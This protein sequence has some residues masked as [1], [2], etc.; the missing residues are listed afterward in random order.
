[1]NNLSHWK[2]YCQLRDIE[3]RILLHIY[4]FRCLTLDQI[5][6]LLYPKEQDRTEQSKQYVLHRCYILVRLKIL[7]KETKRNEYKIFFLTSKGIDCLR[8]HG[9]L[10]AEI[11]LNDKNI[12]GYLTAKELQVSSPAL[13]HQIALNNF[14]IQ[15][16]QKS[17]INSLNSTFRLLF[18]HIFKPDGIIS[19]KDLDIFLEMDM[20]TESRTV[21]N[22]K[23][24]RYSH[25]LNNY[26]DKLNNT[27]LF[28][29]DCSL[30]GRS[31]LEGRISLVRDS[32][33][34]EMGSLMNGHIEAYIGDA[35]ELIGTLKNVVENRALLWQWAYAN[36]YFPYNTNAYEELFNGIRF[37]CLF[38]DSKTYM[39]CDYYESCR[40][41]V[42]YKLYRIEQ[43]SRLFFNSQKSKFQYF[44][45]LKE[46]EL[47]PFIE[48]VKDLKLYSVVQS[49]LVKIVKLEI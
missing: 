25:Y 26:K 21:L 1:M 38:I 31:S 12:C 43:L 2:D 30:S 23:W 44:I 46:H 19:Q 8:E 22:T 39:F 7:Q 45:V 34:N 24:T 41:S 11:K 37:D 33:F 4:N 5:H 29:I 48:H 47:K 40:M 42:F 15:G 27:L 10:K 6:T 18:Y 36:Q 20:C 32:L 14:I 9:D 28:I 16:I 17:L 49:N 35:A 13:P 3:F